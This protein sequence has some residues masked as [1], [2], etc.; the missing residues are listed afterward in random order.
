MTAAELAAA[1]GRLSPAQKRAAYLVA[2]HPTKGL[3]PFFM[4]PKAMIMLRNAVEEKTD[5]HHD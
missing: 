2:K 4:D 3:R 5:A 1:L